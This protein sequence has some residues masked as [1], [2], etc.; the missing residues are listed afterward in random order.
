MRRLGSAVHGERQA[1]EFVRPATTVLTAAVARRYFLDGAGK[2]EIADEFGVSRFKVARLIELARSSGLVRIEIDYRGSLDL[3]LSARLR[4]AFGLRYA[5]VVDCAETDD[6]RLR[7]ALGRAAA[8]LL[9]EIVVKDDVLGL[10]WSRSSMALRS[11]LTALAPRPVV[12]LTG[13]LRRGDADPDGTDLVRDVA[14]T[15]GGAAY[16][17]TAPMLA[18]D[19]QHAQVA[20]A[21]PQVAR[22]FARFA[23]VT[24]AVVAVGAWQK[25]L[26]TVADAVSP[27]EWTRLHRLGVR[28]ELGGIP[29]D[30]DG[31]VVTSPLAQRH[32]GIGADELRAVPDVIALGYGAAKAG[33]VRA[34]IRGGLVNSVV[35]HTALARQLLDIGAAAGR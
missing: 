17:F 18:A 3:E 9:G 32:V 24:K 13:T 16:Y 1:A 20:R 7:A 27:T 30:A 10:A 6:A 25:G 11:A 5:L 14:H 19:E 29:F 28:A 12:Q 26:S 15:S 33:A 31:N 21:D 35:T 34:A 2:S 22:A 8:G 4:A 23:D